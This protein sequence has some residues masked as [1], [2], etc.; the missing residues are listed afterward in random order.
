MRT[1]TKEAQTTPGPTP[2]ATTRGTRSAPSERSSA[3]AAGSSRTARAT[4]CTPL[5]PELAQLVHVLDLLTDAEDVDQQGEPHHRLGGGDHHGHE[6][7]QLSL[8]VVEL[9]RE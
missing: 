3:P 5:P 8:E 9:P 6:D 2:R 1:Q 7:E 4:D